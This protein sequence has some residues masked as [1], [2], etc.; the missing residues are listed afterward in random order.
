[1]NGEMTWPGELAGDALLLA[2]RRAGLPVAASVLPRPTAAALASPEA[3]VSAL[4]GLL[5]LEVAR[6]DVLYGDLGNVL[7]HA[8]LALVPAAGRL[9]VIVRGRVLAPDGLLTRCHPGEL[10]EAACGP[11]ET[12]ARERL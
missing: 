2:A 7:R 6:H 10:V 12:A 11:L 3:W 5:G 1:M 8:D 4:A 9:L